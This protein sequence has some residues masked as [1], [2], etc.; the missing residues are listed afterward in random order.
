[1]ISYSESY[2]LQYFIVEHYKHTDEKINTVSLLTTT[3]YTTKTSLSPQKC[4]HF[5][6]SWWIDAR[7]EKKARERKKKRFRITILFSFGLLLP[8]SHWLS[9]TGL[10]LL[11]KTRCNLSCSFHSSCIREEKGTL[12]TTPNASPYTSPPLC[13]SS[14]P[15]PPPQPYTTIYMIS[16]T[17]PLR[18]I[19]SIRRTCYRHP[20]ASTYIYCPQV[21]GCREGLPLHWI[22]SLLHLHWN[23]FCPH[24]NKNTN[25]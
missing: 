22:L 6:F 8:D 20:L 7:E 4:N 12:L 2:G 14:H 5:T 23:L 24:L 15:P 1:M 19:L 17:A 11:S 13:T 18:P 25:K 16:Y 21:A 10:N 9:R 3:P